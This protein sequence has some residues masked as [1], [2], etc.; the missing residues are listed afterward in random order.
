MR[1]ATSWPLLNPVSPFVAEK[2]ENRHPCRAPWFCVAAILGRELNQCNALLQHT[3]TRCHAKYFAHA[4][5]RRCPSDSVQKLAMSLADAQVDLNPHQIDAAL[6]A[7]RSRL[8]KGANLPE[9]LKL[10]RQKRQLETKRD[11]AWRAYEIAAREIEQRKDALMDE[12]EKKLNQQI[13][14]QPLFTIRWGL[15]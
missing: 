2:P 15:K 12:V 13:A 9:K 14:E 1:L 6:F 5:I 11:E 8:S 4:L 7:F 3:I 10:E